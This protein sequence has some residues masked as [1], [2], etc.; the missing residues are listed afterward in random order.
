MLS[1]FSA[2]SKRT[3]RTIRKSIPA[4]PRDERSYLP[5]PRFLSGSGIMTRPLLICW[6]IRS[7]LTPTRTLTRTTLE[8]LPKIA[9]L[10]RTTTRRTQTGPVRAPAALGTLPHKMPTP[11]LSKPIPQALAWH[12]KVVYSFQKHRSRLP[13]VALSTVGLVDHQWIVNDA[14]CT[15]PALHPLSRALARLWRPSTAQTRCIGCQVFFCF[16]CHVLCIVS[17]SRSIVC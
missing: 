10:K 15:P 6:S 14:Q 13:W 4:L 2:N 12:L 16:T 17:V 9:N 11:K 5:T 7:K 3:S 8:M 1:G